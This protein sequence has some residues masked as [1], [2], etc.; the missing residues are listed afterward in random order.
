M[1][2][3]CF[4]SFIDKSSKDIIDVSISEL[5]KSNFSQ[6]L[7]KFWRKKNIRVKENV[8]LKN[9]KRDYCKKKKKKKNSGERWRFWYVFD[10]KKAKGIIDV[11]F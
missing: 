8:T 5:N 10:D 3:F 1:L 2:C 9:L 4:Y 6:R 11:S 7:Q